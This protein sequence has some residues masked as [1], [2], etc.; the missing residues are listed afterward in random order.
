M[1]TSTIRQVTP[2]R[3]KDSDTQQPGSVKR[4]SGSA[5][6]EHMRIWGK[7]GHVLM[8][9]LHFCFALGGVVSPLVTEP[10]L[11]AKKNGETAEDSANLS[12]HAGSSSHG[13]YDLRDSLSRGSSYR[14]NLSDLSP[15][16]NMSHYYDMNHLSLNTSSDNLRLQESRQTNVHWAFLITGII[17]ILSS[18]PFI[19]FYCKSRQTDTE[20][21]TDTNKDDAVYQRKIPLI[22]HAILVV[23]L[24]AFYL[25]YC[26]VQDTFASFLMTFVVRRFRAVS[27]SDGAHITAVYW[28]S[29]AASRFLMIFV[30]R[31]LSPVRVLYVGGSLMLLSF[32]GFTFSSGPWVG[33]GS[34][35]TAHAMYINASSDT[36]GVTETT[37]DIGSYAAGVDGGSVPILTAFTAMAG[38]AMSGVF[39][40][41]LSWNGAELLKVTGRISSC[42]FISA[43]LGA[44]LNPLLVSRLMQD[45]SNMWFCYVLLLEVSGLTLI[46]CSLLAFNR[47]YLNKRYG[48]LHGDVVNATYTVGIEKHL[49]NN[50]SNAKIFE[51]A[52]IPYNEALQ[53]NGHVKALKYAGKKTN[54]TTENENNRKETPNKETKETKTTN[55][56]KRRI[57]WL[58]SP[59]S[60]NVSTNI[61]KNFSISSTPASHRTT[62]YTKS[63]TKTPSNSAIAVRPT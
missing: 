39:P 27:K 30:S 29:F 23:G 18:I 59:N 32:T 15:A 43:S 62:S 19:F 48:K 34:D 35:S 36:S 14:I 1:S 11:A 3:L 58:N 33:G 8:Q 16:L 2:G 22:A 26:S 9:L 5:N 17:V 47:C 45:V 57:T 38:L 51:D 7:D 37:K 49:T 41:S 44:M 31:V 13:D 12:S 54:T 42:I 63:S 53:K 40:A 60:K 55:R 6:A 52:S 4:M 50:S 10:F 61:G 28:S 20:V 24:G 21:Q 46:F 56:G 25:Q